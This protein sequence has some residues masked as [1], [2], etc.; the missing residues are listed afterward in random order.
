MPARY[1]RAPGDTQTMRRLLLLAEELANLRH[2]RSHAVTL[3]LSQVC[4]RQQAHTIVGTGARHL[5]CVVFVSGLVMTGLRRP[6]D[7][8]THAPAF[9]RSRA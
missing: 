3:R 2:E 4:A 5:G 1:S 6:L 7:V 8:P 9:D